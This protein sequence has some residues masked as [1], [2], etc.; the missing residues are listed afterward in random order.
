MD[1]LL[2][3]KNIKEHFARHKLYHPSKSASSSNKPFCSYHQTQDQHVNY[4]PH[5][6]KGIQG[7]IDNG[8]IKIIENNPSPSIY[9][10]PTSQETRPTPIDD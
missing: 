6:Q 5:F 9:P 4:C 7:L 2:E 3:A 10:C 1:D 8:T